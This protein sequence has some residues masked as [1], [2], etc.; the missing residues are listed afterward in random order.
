MKSKSR[1]NMETDKLIEGTYI[2][3]FIKAQRIKMAGTYPNN[4]PSKTN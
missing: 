4:G 3:R 1:N 2:L